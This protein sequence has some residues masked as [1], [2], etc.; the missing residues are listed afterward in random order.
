MTPRQRFDKVLNFEAPDRLPMLEWAPWWD[1]TIARWEKEGL[2]KGLDPEGIQRYFGLDVMACIG[3]S[4]RGSEGPQTPV[5]DEASY[6]KMRPYLFPEER[7]R[8]L[9]TC[10]AGLKARH[11]RGEL[12]IRLWLDGFFWFPRLLFGIENHL[13]AF[14]DHPELMQQMNRELVEYHRRTIHALCSVLIPDMAGFA[15]DMSYNS[16]PMLSRECFNEFLLPC[17]RQVVPL[18]KE[19]GVKVFVDTDGQVEFM[20]PWLIEAGVEGVY[21]LERQSGVDVVKIRRNHPR[22]LMMGG[23]DKMIMAKGEAAM[24]AEFERLLPIMA[25]G[26]FIP[27]VDHQTPPGVSFENYCA[28]VKLFREFAD[29]KTEA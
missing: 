11:D 2:P 28:Y 18:L 14:F 8:D 29:R 5:T 16:G 24:R 22:F 23:F 19:K 15:E 3:I 9:E 26:G 7:I 1:Q 4:P 12:V 10:A 17:Y 21:P 25:S 6:E 27:S 20:I 13:Y